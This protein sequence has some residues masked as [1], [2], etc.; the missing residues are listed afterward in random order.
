MTGSNWLNWRTQA[1]VKAI[2][3]AGKPLKSSEIAEIT[4]LPLTAVG[5]YINWNMANVWVRV[6]REETDPR[7]GHTV[8]YYG[9][10]SRGAAK[11]EAVQ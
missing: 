10:T 8:K 4:G 9:L 5:R 2:G 7:N 11:L 3:E 6:M 1:I